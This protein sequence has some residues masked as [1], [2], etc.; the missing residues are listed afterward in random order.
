MI[1]VKEGSTMKIKKNITALA[2]MLSIPIMS[3]FYNVLNTSERGF[4]SLATDLDRAIPFLKVFVIPYIIWYL[5]IFL[6][7]GYLCFKDRKTYYRTLLTYNIGL[8]ICYVIYYFYQTSVFRPELIGEDIFTKLVGFIYSMD[9]PYNCF[10]SIHSLGCFLMMKAIN[11][12]TARNIVNVILIN[13]IAI[14]IILSTLFIKQHVILDAIAS[15]ILVDIIY[16]MV[17][18]FDWGR[19]VFWLKQLY[20]SLTMKSKLEV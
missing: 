13:G 20:L 3:V 4:N 6:V 11:K 2:F 16:K 14:S 10:P 12:S 1:I 8:A 17:Y 5:F 18:Y 19:I 9:Q 15:M 7:L